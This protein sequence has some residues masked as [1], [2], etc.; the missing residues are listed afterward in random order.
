MNREQVLDKI[1]LIRKNYFDDEGFFINVHKKIK[2]ISELRAQLKELDN[3]ERANDIIWYMGVKS[4]FN[5][6]SIVTDRD[7]SNIENKLLSYM[8][9]NP[10]S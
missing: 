10:C 2:Q 9:Y 7:L 8:G 5:K 4:R 1:E 6:E 3:S